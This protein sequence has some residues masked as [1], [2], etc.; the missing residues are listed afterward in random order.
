MVH[1]R[2]LAEHA[3]AD[4]LAVQDGQIALEATLRIAML[5]I[6]PQFVNRIRIIRIDRV[7]HL[8]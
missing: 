2:T 5:V 6:E 1:T 3:N 8:G 4:D 7:L